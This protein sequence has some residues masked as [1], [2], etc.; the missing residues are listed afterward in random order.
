MDIKLQYFSHPRTELRDLYMNI[1]Q[2]AKV[3]QI[4]TSFINYKRS[5]AKTIRKATPDRLLG[6]R[7]PFR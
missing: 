4:C 3:V 7:S 2:R 5:Y 6:S 1:K